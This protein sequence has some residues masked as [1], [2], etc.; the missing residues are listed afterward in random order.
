[1][2]D[3]LG[4]F[5][6]TAAIVYMFWATLEVLGHM[7]MHRA[8]ERK[9]AWLL[10]YFLAFVVYGFWHQPLYAAAPLFILPRF[11]HVLRNWIAQQVLATLVRLSGGKY[12]RLIAWLGIGADRRVS[13]GEEKTP[14]ISLE[15]LPDEEALPPGPLSAP[16]P[17]TAWQ[18]IKVYGFPYL[19]L[20]ISAKGT[21]DV[22]IAFYL[23]KNRESPEMTEKEMYAFLQCL[24]SERW[25][26]LDCPSTVQ[27]GVPRKL[28]VKLLVSPLPD[29]S[30]YYVRAEAAKLRSY[31]YQYRDPLLSRDLINQWKK[32][33]QD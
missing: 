22:V 33:Y 14:Y 27:E 32:E 18:V 8:K 1:M 19:I 26:L 20:T 24:E 29:L 13:D 23:G 4:G 6:N 9:W 3:L 5:L 2:N 30:A 7:L 10:A 12:P 16:E 28:R 31:P 25:L 15:I 17:R 11:S 21:E